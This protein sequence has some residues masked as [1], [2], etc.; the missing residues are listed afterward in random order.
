VSRRVAPAEP[1]PVYVIEVDA[2]PGQAGVRQIRWAAKRLL[3]D[4][5]L[6]CISIAVRRPEREPRQ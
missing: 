4:L 1:R 2:R 5:K 3:R 6:R